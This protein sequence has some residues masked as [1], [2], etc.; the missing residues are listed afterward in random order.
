MILWWVLFLFWILQITIYIFFF[1]KQMYATDLGLLPERDFQVIF[2]FKQETHFMFRID[3]LLANFLRLCRHSMCWYSK[4]I[5][6]KLWE[7]NTEIHV[8]VIEHLKYGALPLNTTK[9]MSIQARQSSTQLLAVKSTVSVEKN[10]FPNKEFLTLERRVKEILKP[11]LSKRSN[12]IFESSLSAQWHPSSD[13]Q[14]IFN[15]WKNNNLSFR[16]ICFLDNKSIWI[17]L[18]EEIPLILATGVP[19]GPS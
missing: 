7:F 11:I 3:Y 5:C 1:Q 18:E 6:C 14:F 4:I 12:I 17:K 8:C 2:H 9:Q 19:P 16:R 15:A 13:S 10:G